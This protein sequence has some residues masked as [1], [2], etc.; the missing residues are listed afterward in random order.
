MVIRELSLSECLEALGRTRVARLGCAA[1]G[2][3]YVVPIFFAL[4][5]SAENGPCLYGFTTAG[6]KVRW[7]RANP[8]VCVE[9]DEVEEYDRWVSVIVFG[10]YEELSDAAPRPPRGA[11]PPPRN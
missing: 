8:H 5:R 4:D 3:P 11:P 7:M 9:W 1:D 10:R 2:Q 6:Q